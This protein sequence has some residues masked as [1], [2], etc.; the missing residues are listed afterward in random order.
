MRWSSMFAAV[1]LASGCVLLLQPNAYSQTV[2]TGTAFGTSASFTVTT[3]GTSLTGASFV[4]A[5][6]DYPQLGDNVTGPAGSPGTT[7]IKVRVVGAGDTSQAN[8]GIPNIAVRLEAENTAAGLP[9]I[10]C[11]GNNG[12]ALTD[13]AGT[14]TCTPIFGKALGT[15]VGFRG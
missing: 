6:L 10:A 9:S 5:L 12:I 13:T 2:V 8:V 11:S 15:T 3:V 7:P 14:A 4:Q 1:L